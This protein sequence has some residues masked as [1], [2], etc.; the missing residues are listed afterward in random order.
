MAQTSVLDYSCMRA[1]DMTDEALDEIERQDPCFYPSEESEKVP[2]TDYHTLLL[3]MLRTLIRVVLPLSEGNYLASNF[4]YWMRG[5]RNLRIGPDLYLIKGISCRPRRV[6]KVWEEGRTPDVV[7]EVL[8]QNTYRNDLT[9]RLQTYQDD[10]HVPE[11]FICDPEAV[12]SSTLVFG[13]RLTDGIYRPIERVDDR[14]PS[15]Q[16]GADLVE[17][18]AQIRLYD[19]SAGLLIPT[20]EEQAAAEAAAR[21]QAEAELAHLRV[22]L[23]RLREAR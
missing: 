14:L 10:L 8:S 19:P 7:F 21:Q 12:H 17:D 3:E 15:E 16:L 22:E 4:I 6:F 9:T 18:G 13:Y 2:E 11:Y 1:A 5:D 20:P 23:E